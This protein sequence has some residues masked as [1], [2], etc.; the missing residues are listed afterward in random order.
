MMN[1]LIQ[2]LT[3]C[4]GLLINF[5]IPLLFGL[6]EYGLFI[7]ANILVFF[8][9]KLTDVVSEPLISNVE[10]KQLL[11]I[12]LSFGVFIL[13]VFQVINSFFQSGSTYLLSAMIWSNAILLLLFALNL[14][15]LV[16]VYLSGFIAM[17]LTLLFSVYMHVIHLTIT[18][19]CSFTNFIPATLC[20]AYTLTL[21][22][23]PFSYEGLVE[24]FIKTIR[25]M[26]KLFSLTLVNNLF[27][28]ILLFY[29]SFIFPPQLLGL[30]RVQVSIVQS[31]VALFPI[32]SKV[33]STYFLEATIESN[34]IEK[35]LLFSLNYFYLIA[36]AGFL[37]VGIYQEKPEFSQVFLLLPI[38]HASIIVERYM[39]G[40]Y[41]RQQLMMINIIITIFSCLTVLCIHT[42]DQMV[43]LYSTGIS[44][45]LLIMLFFIEK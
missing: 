8:F 11:P 17:F 45:Y 14:R 26:P 29:L 10:K 4:S 33:L 9:H 30:Y 44:L 7:K 36:L 28:N 41:M 23:V 6:E 39:L 24:N 25:I 1:L 5:L 27:S 42:L 13:L 2:I 16:V 20:L 34:F 15:K 19:V 31:V 40:R 43:I 38:V 12:S 18:Q 35:L 22:K 3:L 37:I 21:K 32:N